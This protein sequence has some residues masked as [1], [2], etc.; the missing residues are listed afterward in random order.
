MDRAFIRKPCLL[1]W[2]YRIDRDDVWMDTMNNTN[3]VVYLTLSTPTGSE[4]VPSETVLNHACGWAENKTT[5]RFR[6]RGYTQ[7]WIQESLYV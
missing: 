3:H 4:S 7:Q 5:A 6:L 1:Q 2:R